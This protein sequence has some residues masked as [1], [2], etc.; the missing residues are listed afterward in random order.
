MKLLLYLILL[1]FNLNYLTAQEID[2]DD[3]NF[4]IKDSIIENNRVGNIKLCDSL[5]MDSLDFKNNWSDIKYKAQKILSISTTN[6]SKVSSIF[7]VSPQF[8]LK[9]KIKVGMRI[10]DLIQLYPKLK[11][12][13]WHAGLYEHVNLPDFPNIIL[14]LKSD[15]GKELGF[16]KKKNITKKY[17]LDGE[18]I[19]I[20]LISHNCY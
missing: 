17:R 8:T 3:Y 4:I 14:A 5:K 16:Y 18:I 9:E 2:L 13:R 10:K 7:V 11:I 12:F 6:K 15:N 19:G 20:E 1:T